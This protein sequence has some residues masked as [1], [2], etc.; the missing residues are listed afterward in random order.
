M[1]TF[2]RGRLDGARL[3]HCQRTAELAAELCRRFGCRAGKARAAGLAHDLARGASASELLGLAGLDGEPISD[4]ERAEP[5][6]LHG[7]AAAALLARESVTLDPE[8]ASAIRHHVTGRPGMGVLA[9]VLFCADYLEP[10][11]TF[12]DPAERRQMLALDLPAM[13]LAVLEGKLRW[14]ATPARASRQMHE[15]LERDA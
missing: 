6:L 5:M 13:T 9:R 8:I 11:R 15:E 12:L 4:E 14:V 2:V 1:E 3:A 7:R 10:G